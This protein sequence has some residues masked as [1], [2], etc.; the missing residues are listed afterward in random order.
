MYVDNELVF[1][2]AVA[3]TVTANSSVID[4]TGAGVGNQPAMTAGINAGGTGI[5]GLDIGAGDGVAVPSLNVNVGTTFTAGGSATLTIALQA[6][7]ANSSNAAAGY[8]TLF[9]SN[10]I[11]VAQLIAGASFNFPIPPILLAEVEALPRFYRLTYTVATGPFTAGALSAIIALGQPNTST[12]G[13]EGSQVPN[14][15]IAL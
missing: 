3:L 6:S 2:N 12:Y 1:S 8:V 14:N 4:V 15:F 5:I 7:A 10:A 9:T 11:P 13:N